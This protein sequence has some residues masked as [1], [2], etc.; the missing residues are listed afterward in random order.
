MAT[1]K[2]DK[3]LVIVESPHKAQVIQKFLGSDY[4]ALASVG[5]IRDLPKSGSGK[6]ALGIDVEHDFAMRYAIIKG[7]EK[8]LEELKNAARDASVVYLAPDPDREGEAIAWHL[9]EALGLKD[10]QVQRITYTAVTK[11]AVLEAMDRPRAINMDLVNA[12]QARRALDRLVGFNLSPF[13]WKKVA[14]NLSA[15]RVQSPAV[16]IIVE[17]EREI[18]VFETQEYWSIVA[19]IFPQASK[20]AFTASLVSWQGVKFALG[21]PMAATVSQVDEVLAKV[22]KAPLQLLSVETKESSSKPSPPF[23]TSTLQQA[24]NIYLRYSAT[25]IMRLAQRLYE[26]VEIDGVPTGLITYMRTDSVSIDPSAMAEARS[27]LSSR[28]GDEFIPSKPTVYSSGKNAQEAHEAIRPTVVELTPSQ[29]KPYLK[30]DEFRLYELIWRRFM[31]SQM[32]PARYA[33]TVAKIAVDEG[34]FEARGRVLLF[35]G[36][37]SLSKELINEDSEGAEEEPE[38][39]L[40]PLRVGED[41]TLKQVDGVQHFTKPPARF[42]EASLVKSLEKEGIGRPSTYA[43][44]IQT[45]LERGYVIQKERTFY[46]TELGMAVTDIL[47]DNFSDIVN[48]KFTADMEMRLDE[49]EHGTQDWV[50]LL[51]N[52]Y[53]PFIK[54]LTHALEFA[55]PVKG[56]VW[57]GKEK[58]PICGSGL[59]IRYSKAG[60]F[61]GCD[62]YP[63]CKGLL[64]MVGQQGD[65]VEDADGVKQQ[66]VACSLCD[67]PMLLKKS[68]FGQYFYACSGYPDCKGTVS[69]DKEGQ[70]VIPPKTEEKCHICGKP[71]QVKLSRSGSFL[72]CTGYPAC[73]NTMAL[74]ADGTVEH[75]PVLEEPVVCEKCGKPMH[76]K[77]GPRGWFMA[78]SGY[79]KC[80]N[81]KPLPGSEEIEKPQ[82]A[83]RKTKKS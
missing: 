70:P 45:V 20:E 68:R 26:G 13:L 12:Q 32:S 42:N 36:F 1:K 43:P 47:R 65:A 74:K 54:Q 58:C 77:R 18:A 51:R 39:R 50:S 56:R 21:H 15:G 80:R 75:A 9:K 72:A 55:D 23:T 41:L 62:T 73:L 4:K 38:N 46:A 8:K 2:I 34:V 22:R 40:P 29:A 79:P 5:H 19:Q 10:S 14:R 52:F 63:K 7:K 27:Y 81:A 66:D 60:A 48:I 35:S 57:T 17:R 37:L 64:P 59:V 71:M 31:Q 24:A 82:R 3:K 6:G 16:R 67:K 76:V 69:V 33:G 11:K 61:L 44:I 83:F 25:R 30:P 49:V 53:T 28:F 78:C